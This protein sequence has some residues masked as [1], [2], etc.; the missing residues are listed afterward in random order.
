MIIGLVTQ[1]KRKGEIAG[2]MS[3]SKEESPIPKEIPII[4]ERIEMNRSM[5]VRLSTLSF[6]KNK[7]RKREE[8]NN[9]DK[10]WHT[11]IPKRHLYSIGELPSSP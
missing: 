11:M 2:V 9:S 7:V 8:K 10:E 5:L 4:K 6:S 3:W 1:I